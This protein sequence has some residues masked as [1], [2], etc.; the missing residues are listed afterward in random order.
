MNYLLPENYNWHYFF[1]LIITTLAVFISFWN[2]NVIFPAL[3][4]TLGLVSTAMPAFRQQLPSFSFVDAILAVLLVSEVLNYNYSIYA[5]NSFVFLQKII[6][7]TLLYSLLRLTFATN[8]AKNS[9]LVALSGYGF[10]LAMGAFLTFILLQTQLQLEGWQDA[11]Q[12]K[13]LYSPFGLLNNE[14]ATIALCL[15]PFPLIVAAFFSRFKI[16]LLVC[17]L[18]FAMVNASALVSFSRGA[19]LSLG[20]FWLIAIVSIFYFK[21]VNYK[22]LLKII[23]VFILLIILF[24]IPIRI[25]FFT[26]LAMNKTVTQQRSTQGRFDILESGLCL[27]KNNWWLGVGG[28]NYPIVNDQCTTPREDQGYSGFTNNTYL[29][30]LIEKGIL[31]LAAY[32]LFFLAIIINFIRNIIRETDQTMRLVNSLLLAGFLTFCF[33]ELFF[34]SFLYS[35]GVLTLVSVFAAASAAG[36]G[37]KFSKNNTFWVLFG[38]ILVLGISW[39]LYQES[40]Y[41]KAEQLVQQAIIQW[42]KGDKVA[43]LI[44]VEKAIQHAPNVAP[45]HALAGLIEGQTDAPLS[46]FLKDSVQTDKI[47]ITNSI[48]HFKKALQLNPL[49]AGYHFNLGWLHF[50][51]NRDSKTG[52]EYLN[53]ALA[54]EPNNSEFLIGKGIVLEYAKDTTAAFE[55]YKKAVRLDPEILDSKYYNDIMNRNSYNYKEIIEKTVDNFEENPSTI[56]AARLGKLLINTENI[57]EAKRIL[58][59]VAK[60]LPD[61]NR[62]YYHLAIIAEREGDTTQAMSLLRQAMYLD[63]MDYLPV[64][65]LGHIYYNRKSEQKNAA[66]TVIRYYQDALRNWWSSSSSNH[67]GRANIKYKI[68]TA[69]NNDLIPKDLL[70][71]IKTQLDFQVITIRIAEMYVKLDNKKE[72]AYYK[73]LSQKALSEIKIE[74]IQ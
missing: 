49:D 40:Y 64:L 38:V 56:I 48:T 63:G 72:A 33:R 23:S 28:N 18:A 52:L 34:S 11:S 6:F 58:Q 3:A 17:A 65:E 1:L 9:I 29:Q 51:Q 39:I 66:F 31:G 43:A 16:A 4:L 19:Y 32:G 45:Y 46:D 21:L 10:L 37:L 15:L 35:N 27:A 68:N 13:R 69:V 50:L 47:S 54:L 67:N 30:L 7:F 36:N 24:I 71:G 53:R 22:K 41:K 62:P 44:N 2:I 26:T 14:W 60:E 73:M 70:L 55:A 57:Q 20:L 8:T 61:L 74:D 12:F 25:P 42:N 59:R 5:P